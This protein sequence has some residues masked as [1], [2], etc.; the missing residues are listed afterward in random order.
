METVFAIRKDH[1]N[2]DH[3]ERAIKEFDVV[4]RWTQFLGF[5]GFPGL[6]AFCS[7]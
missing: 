7:S 4:T 5:P 3:F 1:V 6:V 2:S